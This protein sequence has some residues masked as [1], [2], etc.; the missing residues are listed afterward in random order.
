MLRS[1]LISVVVP[2]Y[3][4][5]KYVKNCLENLLNQTYSEIEIIVV[6]DGSVDNSYLIAK[7]F[8]VKVIR[9]ENNCGLSIARNTGLSA[10]TGQ[11]IHFM[12]VDDMVNQQYYQRLVEAI[13]RTGADLACGGMINKKAKHKTV[14]F[15]QEAVYSKTKAKMRATYVGK[16]GFVWRYLFRRDFLDR[17]KLR[18]EEGRFVEDLMFSITAV[19]HAQKMVVVPGAEY[20]YNDSEN[21]ILTC[22][23][24]VHKAKVHQDWVHARKRM[25]DF[26][27]ANSFSIPGVNSGKIRYGLWKL[28]N[29]WFNF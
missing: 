10:A 15:K 18:F 24:E 25:F 7:E 27:S 21:S 2:V 12:D 28:K 29:L 3:N 8:P 5:E 20:T 4:G 17:H 9:L 1:E 13:T 11:Y 23:D 26:A 16:W 19:F 14:L 6:D 22:V